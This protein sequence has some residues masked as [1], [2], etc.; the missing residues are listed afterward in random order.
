MDAL[1][2]RPVYPGQKERDDILQTAS[3]LEQEFEAFKEKLVKMDHPE[4][5]K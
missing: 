3:E 2:G 5:G 4:H 1:N